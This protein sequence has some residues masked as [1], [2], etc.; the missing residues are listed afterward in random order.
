MNEAEQIQQV[1]RIMLTAGAPVE[2]KFDKP[3]GRFL[4]KNFS[5]GAVYASFEKTVDTNNSIKILSQMFQVCEISERGGS[6]G[7][8]KTFSIYL[9]G[10]G[11]VEVQEL[12]V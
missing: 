9:T 3:S 1:K 7:Q 8:P 4:V 11:E 2:V 10:S 6:D 5:A 12:W